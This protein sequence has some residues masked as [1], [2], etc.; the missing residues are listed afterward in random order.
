MQHSDGASEVIAAQGEALY[1]KTIRDKVESA[2]KGKF[3]AIDIETGD[4]A[5]ADEDLVATDRLLAKR[6][7]ATVYGLRIGF[8]TAYRIG[9]RFRCQH[10]DFRKN[11]RESRSHH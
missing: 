11:H 6:P 5:I 2:Y 7:N 1:Q 8:P 3:L 4:Y 10:N 9:L